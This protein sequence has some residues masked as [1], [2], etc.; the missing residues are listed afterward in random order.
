[1]PTKPAISNP[2]TP[3][4]RLRL[5]VKARQQLPKK[6]IWEIIQDDGAGRLSIIKTSQT[7]YDA[8]ETAYEYGKPVLMA[9][10]AAKAQS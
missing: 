1:M 10:R 3:M 6:F 2:H 9:L 4:E 8:M 7:A 5:I